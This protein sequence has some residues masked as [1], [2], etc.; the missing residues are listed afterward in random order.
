MIV[1]ITGNVSYAITLDPTVWIFDDRKV[2]LDEAFNEQKTTD[3][4][5][6]E[7]RFAA[8]RFSREFYDTKINRPPVKKSITKFE[9]E[10]VLSNSYVMPL[11]DFINNAEAAAEATSAVLETAQGETSINFDDLK[12]GYFLFAVDGKPITED[13][14]VHFLYKDGSNRNSPVKAVKKI[15]IR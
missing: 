2:L 1:Q 13:G 6:D 15:V 9:A 14:P 4:D 11:V 8:E 5:T 7:I 12:E 3:E 10:K